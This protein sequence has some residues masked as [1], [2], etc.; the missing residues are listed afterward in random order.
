MKVKTNTTVS[1]KGQITIPA[2]LRR[3]LGSMLAI[4]STSTRWVGV[5]SRLN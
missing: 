5:T 2:A 1:S 4:A 3:E